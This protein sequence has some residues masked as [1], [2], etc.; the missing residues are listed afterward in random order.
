[1]VLSVQHIDNKTKFEEKNIVDKLFI[2]AFSCQ[3]A[4][5]YL[6]RWIYVMWTYVHREFFTIFG[7]CINVLNYKIYYY[8]LK[9]YRVRV[10]RMCLRSYRRR[11]YI[12]SLF[13]S[14]SLSR[15][16][17]SSSP[18]LSSWRLGPFNSP[19]PRCSVPGCSLCF[20]PRSN[21]SCVLSLLTILRSPV[22]LFLEKMKVN[23][24][25]SSARRQIGDNAC[26][27]MANPF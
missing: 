10:A 21:H 12:V 27:I 4:K 11:A 26:L 18:S 6:Y 17:S 5:I 14:H 25:R 23:G 2:F 19:L 24:F 15:S 13:L 1:M 3:H 8:V 20:S 16:S 9:N 22:V 7:Q